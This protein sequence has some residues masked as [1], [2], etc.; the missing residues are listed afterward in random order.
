MRATRQLSGGGVLRGCSIDKTASTHNKRHLR[1]ISRPEEAAIQITSWRSGPLVDAYYSKHCM[2][3]EGDLALRCGQAHFIALL[4]LELITPIKKSPTPRFIGAVARGALPSLMLIGTN[5][6]FTC[7]QLVSHGG[8][9]VSWA[10][11]TQRNT[12]R[13]VGESEFISLSRY[14]LY[15]AAVYAS[16]QSVHAAVAHSSKCYSEGERRCRSG[17][18]QFQTRVGTGCCDSV[19]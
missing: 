7:Q 5:P 1:N 9:P 11:K 6:N 8:N 4:T 13:S 10:S 18:S 15:G 12:E 14:A 16:A 19:Y 2:R 3:L 17:S